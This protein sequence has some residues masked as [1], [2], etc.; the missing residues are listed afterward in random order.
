MTTE[1]LSGSASK[2]VLIASPLLIRSFIRTFTAKLFRYSH[3]L[4]INDGELFKTSFNRFSVAY[5]LVYS[6]LYGTK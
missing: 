5:S 3:S 1:R 6:Y 4:G 2:Q